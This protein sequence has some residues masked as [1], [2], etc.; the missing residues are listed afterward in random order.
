[1]TTETISADPE[2]V[3]WWSF[4]ILFILMSL[5]VWLPVEPIVWGFPLWAAATLIFM[6]A[7]ALVA[8]IAG[9]H[10]EWPLGQPIGDEKQ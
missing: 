8:A 5:A 10:Y 1:M 9:V 6:I 3:L 2:T 7:A 4:G